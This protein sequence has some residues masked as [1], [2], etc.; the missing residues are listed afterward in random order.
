M[1]K[2]WGWLKSWFD[3]QHPAPDPVFHPGMVPPW[4]AVNR[5]MANL[6]DQGEDASD[7]VLLVA[8]EAV[9]PN[10]Y[11]GAVVTD[12]G[13]ASIQTSAEMGLGEWR[14]VPKP[15]NT[16]NGVKPHD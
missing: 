3:H 9:Y 13:T 10:D 1:K 5:A 11:M 4:P 14:L 16:S 12:Y 7:C 2:L 6:W 15:V 8:P